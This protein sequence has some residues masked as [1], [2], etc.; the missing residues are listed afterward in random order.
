[1]ERRKIF[2][3]FLFF[4]FIAETHNSQ[5]KDLK[6]TDFLVDFM[7]GIIVNFRQ[8][9]HTQ[10]NNQMVIKVESVKNKEEAKSLINKKVVWKTSSGKELVGKITNFHGNSGAL[11]VYFE[12]GLPG[13]SVGTKVKIEQ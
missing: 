4:Q 2:L 8:G 11:R 3:I 13:Q 1:M 12:K 10:T 9:K 5:S 6:T 7:E